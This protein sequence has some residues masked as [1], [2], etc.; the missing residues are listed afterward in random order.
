MVSLFPVDL[1]ESTIGISIPNTQRGS[2]DVLKKQNETAYYVLTDTWLQL[3]LTTVEPEKARNDNL[4]ANKQL[5]LSPPEANCHYYFA[6]VDDCIVCELVLLKW[7]AQLYLVYLHLLPLDGLPLS[8]SQSSPS[9]EH[10]A[11]SIKSSISFDT[12]YAIYAMLLKNLIELAKSWHCNLL[13]VELFNANLVKIFLIFG[14]KQLDRNDTSIVAE[15]YS[16]TLPI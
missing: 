1:L 16:L 12:A 5:A 6:T 10:S 15:R 7:Q 3:A 9:A 13:Q 11:S 4:Q 2:L 14:F 8:L